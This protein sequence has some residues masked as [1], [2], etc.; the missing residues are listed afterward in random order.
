MADSASI[1][2]KTGREKSLL[3][4]HPWV[5][6]GSVDKGAA[7]AGETVRVQAHDGREL[8]QPLRVSVDAVRPPEDRQVAEEV[9]DDE[10]DHQQARDRHDRARAEGLPR[11][12]PGGRHGRFHFQTRAHRRTASGPGAVGTDQGRKV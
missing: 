12:V 3:R 6:Q 7:D 10:H 1:T 2:L 9:A 11:A 5:F 4:R 8:V